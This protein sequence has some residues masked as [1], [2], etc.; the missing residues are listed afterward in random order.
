MRVRFVFSFFAALFRAVLGFGTS[1]LLARFLGPMDFGNLSFLWASFGAISALL[2]GGTSHAFNAFISKERQRPRFFLTYGLWLGLQLLA[3]IAVVL[4]APVSIANKLWPGQSREL[5]PLAAI[6]CFVMNQLWTMSGQVGESIRRTVEVQIRNILATAVIFLA[7][8]I[9]GN[10]AHLSVTSVLWLQLLVFLVFSIGFLYRIFQGS[11][12]FAIK[13]TLQT[14]PEIVRSFWLY[15][16]PL[17]WLTIL[18]FLFTFLDPWLLQRYAGAAEQGFFGIGY[19]FC[20]IA[21]LFSGAMMQIYFKEASEAF[22]RNDM[23]RLQ[24]IFT[25]TSRFLYFAV[26]A[27]G[28]FLIPFS[29]DILKIT[30]GDDYE[31]AALPLV[32]LFFYPLHNT[33]HTVIDMTFL[34]TFNTHL[35]GR[36]GVIFVVFSIVSAYFLLAPHDAKIPGLGLGAVGLALKLVL[37]QLV[38]CLLAQYCLVRVVKLQF[39]WMHQFLTVALLLPLIFVIRYIVISA[40]TTLNFAPTPLV[41]MPICLLLYS[42]FLFFLVDIYPGLAGLSKETLA[43]LRSRF[44]CCL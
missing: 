39:D 37:C 27:I 16:R 32:I 17:L 21:A 9:I 42:L 22:G 15:C 4:L 33:L 28:C 30:V 44:L 2:D 19:R 18:G 31:R 41:V 36:I 14:I 5:L 23:V 12:L 35:K 8:I 7:V 20:F 26:A 34:A 13:G 6:A 1:L 43:R 40:A 3:L 11:D 29:A 38:Q 25:Q 10:F 24:S